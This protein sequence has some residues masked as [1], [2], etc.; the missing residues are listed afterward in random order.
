MSLQ[1]QKNDI[2]ESEN[3]LFRILEIQQNTAYVISITKLNAP[4]QANLEEI[5]QY[6]K[7]DALDTH[8]PVPTE[9]QQQIMWQR[10]RIILPLIL[11]ACDKRERTRLLNEIAEQENITKNTLKNWLYKYLAYQDILVLC[12]VERDYEEQHISSELADVFRYS[13]NKWYLTPAKTT[14]KHTYER[15]IEK[16]FTDD[17]GV[18]KEEYPSYRQLQY[19][20]QQNITKVNEY[21]SRNGKGYFSR[22]QRPLVHDG[23][24]A[25]YPFEIYQTDAQ[26][27]DLYVFKD[28]LYQEVGRPTLVVAIDV[29]SQAIVGYS[30]SFTSSNTS[31]IKALLFNIIEKFPLPRVLITDRGKEFTSELIEQISIFTEIQVMEG[32]RPDLKGNIE[33]WFDILNDIWTPFFQGKGRVHKAREELPYDMIDYK[34][35]AVIT[36]EQFEKEILVKSIDYYNN[37]HILENYKYTPDMLKAASEDK[38]KPTPTGLIEYATK[39]YALEFQPITPEILTL[40]LLDRTTAKFTRKGLKLTTKLYYYNAD[41]QNEMLIGK[42]TVIVAYDSNN[43]SKIWMIENFVYTPFFLIQE[44]YRDLS[45]SDYDRYMEIEKDLLSRYAKDELQAKIDLNK[46]IKAVVK[47]EKHDKKTS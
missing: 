40:I 33:K 20:K 23:L 35:Q 5:E 13:L 42:K 41:Y 9:R 3:E 27:L 34:S 11:K 14:L 22:N 1:M 2:F 32:Y 29:F 17:S 31:T 19:Y 46:Q 21:C 43:I 30:V 44:R 12:P 26:I 36:L 18:L 16:F 6:K 7:I 39:T 25:L 47:G 15:M 37:D 24:S 38:L 28:Y 4:R 45:M 8:Y 10:Y